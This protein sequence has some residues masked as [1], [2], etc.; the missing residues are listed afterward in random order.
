VGGGESVSNVAPAAASMQ[1]QTSNYGRAIPICYGTNRLAGNLIWYSDFKSTPVESQQ[2][3][4]GGGGGGQVTGYTYKAAAILGL[5][6]GPLGA[7]SERNQKQWNYGGRGDRDGYGSTT[8]SYSGIRTIYQ[9]QSKFTPSQLNLTIALGTATQIAFPYVT[10]KHP[11]EALPYPYLANVASSAYDLGDSPS[12]TQALYEVIGLGANADATGIYDANPFFIAKDL[13]TN[14][15]F[16]ANFPAERVIDGTGNY[17][18]AVGLWLSPVYT[19]QTPAADM[20]TQLAMLTNCQWVWSGGVLTLV[21]YGL[22][23]VTGGPGV[24]LA[25]GYTALGAR[26]YS[27]GALAVPRY[28]LTDDDFLDNGS[29][30]PVLVQRP[31][32]ITAFN[33]IQVQYSN[34]LL[35]YADS[36]SEAK[37][38]A[39]IETYGL[40]PA[41]MVSAPEI[42]DAL[43]A[44]ATAQLLLQRSVYIRNTYKFTVNYRYILLDPMDLVTL[45]EATESGLQNQIVRI[46]SITEND[47]GTLDME[48]EDV[49]G[50]V[51]SHAVYNEQDVGGFVGNY[52]I[53]AGLVAVPV[54]FDAAGRMTQTGYE[55][56]IAAAGIDG[57]PWGGALV[58][59]SLDGA[60][61]KQV[62]TIVGPARY[63]SLT[64]SVA[65]GTD[66]D[67]SH[68][69]PVDLMISGAGLATGSTADAD[70]ANTLCWV[71]GEL[72]AYST[73]TLT[74]LSRYTLQT[75]TRRGI[76]G[77]PNK[78]HASGASFAR[79]DAGLFKYAYDPALIGKTVYLKL[80]SFNTW[81]GGVDDISDTVA[82]AFTIGGPIGAP[83]DVTG[84][85]AGPTLAGIQIAWNAVS[86]PDLSEYEVRQGDTWDTAE[87]LGRSRSTSYAVPPQGAGSWTWWVKA[88][89]K[90]GIYSMAACSVTMTVSAPSAPTVFQQVVDNNVLL[91]WTIAAATQPIATYE[92]RRGAMFVDAH[93]IGTKSGLF[94]SVFETT[95]GTYTYWVVGIDIA[96]NY[97]TPGSVTTV[98]NQPPDY[99]LHGVI[100]STFAGTKAM[101]IIDVDGR[102][103][104]PVDTTMSYADH[105]D[106]NSWANADAQ[107]AAGFP[108]FIQPADS[109]G[110]HSGW[111]EEY[112]VIGAMLAAMKVTVSWAE[113]DIG[114]PAVRC[115]I[116]WSD[117]ET[118]WHTLSD[119]T[120]A[121]ATNFAYLKIRLSANS[122]LGLDLARISDLSV[123]LDAKIKNDGGSIAALAADTAG[124]NVTFNMPFVAI[125]SIT[126]TA[127]QAASGGAASLTPIFIF[128]GAPNPT[129]FQV[130]VFDSAGARV[131]ATVNWAAKGY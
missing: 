39:H 23:E 72:I 59:L 102:L 33:A 1:I 81:G 127:G 57:N 80:Q 3:G 27:P 103:V 10:T 20:L 34:R 107:I 108:I 122:D 109:S 7:F 40:Q 17:L 5:C 101:A 130:M 95:A 75:Y 25:E 71:D 85:A 35:D 42:C 49:V 60:T 79:L 92:I 96:G 6:E 30:D 51:T 15:V 125:T 32:P 44:R 18:W 120:S 43:V 70:N 73:A 97:G 24:T 110:D 117:G 19:E 119:T 12:M 93:V 16:G 52:N 36:I 46:T 129:T 118:G 61:Y 100:A 94:T 116:S 54:I 41:P 68:S 65:A 58:W 114:T 21:P 28:S 50:N 26:T 69:F 55:V 4:K 90:T 9:N 124:T 91:S 2:A 67:V 88:L 123:R 76:Y 112:I 14:P 87:Y 121:Y 89:N 8:H 111:Y 74:A 11:G 62:G 38:Q 13:L 45:T 22:D 47:S 86:A 64:A 126:L 29:T 82:Y 113:I 56:W 77:T 66:P 131:N 115:S 37:D 106:T 31:T 98:V 48:A 78:A 63:G 84:V 53:A 99:V 105:F 83:Q 104:M 128:D